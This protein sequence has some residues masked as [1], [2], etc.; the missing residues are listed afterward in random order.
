[1]SRYLMLDAREVFD[2]IDEAA[3]HHDDEASL[4][5]LAYEAGY[6]LAGYDGLG[7]EDEYQPDCF[8]G[9]N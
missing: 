5:A 4:A 9:D 8:C 1:M 7:E 3:Y 6:D 2:A